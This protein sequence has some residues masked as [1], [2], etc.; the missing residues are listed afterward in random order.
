MLDKAIKSKKE[1][2]K[3]YYDKAKDCDRSCRN[4]GDDYWS[5]S[6][7]THKTRKEKDRTD[8]IMK[9]YQEEEN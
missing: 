8:E 6:N 1:H 4:H 5:L 9:E 3:P 2:R 7:R